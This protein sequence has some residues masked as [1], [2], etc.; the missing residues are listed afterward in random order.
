[1]TKAAAR[2]QEGWINFGSHE[3]EAEEADEGH[4]VAHCPLT[5]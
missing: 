3:I 1:M 4:I 5:L 2:C